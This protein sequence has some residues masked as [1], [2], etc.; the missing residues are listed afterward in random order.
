[1]TLVGLLSG[2]LVRREAMVTGWGRWWAT[3]ATRRRARR[4]R[5]DLT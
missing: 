4:W 5:V 2:A 3:R 1:M